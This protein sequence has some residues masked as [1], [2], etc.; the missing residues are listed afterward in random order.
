M[1]GS[2]P[3]NESIRG[4]KENEESNTATWSNLLYTNES[5]TSQLFIL[6]KHIPGNETKN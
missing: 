2:K 3:L 5:E 4:Q 1:G 6:K